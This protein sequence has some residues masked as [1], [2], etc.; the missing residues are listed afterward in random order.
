MIRYLQ[1]TGCRKIHPKQKKT[2]SNRSGSSAKSKTSSQRQKELLIAEHHK[3]LERQHKNALRLAKRRQQIELQNFQQKQQRLQLEKKNIFIKSDS[4][5]QEQEQQLQF[6]RQRLHTEQLSRVVDF[7][8][9]ARRRIA[10]AKIQLIDDLPDS[11]GN[12]ELKHTLSQLRVASRGAESQRVKD[13]VH[14]G[15]V[16]NCNQ[17]QLIG[18]D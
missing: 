2:V 18:R 7:E 5:L 10:E 16:E 14:N 12:N 4:R 3:K 15:S 13:W 6:E 1:L 9:E 11:N 17:N 8:E